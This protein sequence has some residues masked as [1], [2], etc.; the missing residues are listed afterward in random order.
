MQPN[1]Y[2][3]GQAAVL[4]LTV[5]KNGVATDVI[6]TLMNLLVED[7]TGTITTYTY[8]VDPIIVRVTTGVYTANIDLTISGVYKYRWESLTPNTGA[9][10]SFLIVSP[11]IL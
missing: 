4:R 7:P 1:Q 10:E 5:T 2:L 8:G 11:S 6:S 3:E 9:I